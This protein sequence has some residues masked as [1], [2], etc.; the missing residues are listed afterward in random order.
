MDNKSNTA[1]H[2]TQSQYCF[3]WKYYI[4]VMWSLSRWVKVVT[5]DAS[6]RHVFLISTGRKLYYDVK[7]MQ[8]RMMQWRVFNRFSTVETR[9]SCLSE[10]SSVI[11]FK[12]YQTISTVYWV[13]TPSNLCEY[14]DSKD[15]GEYGEE[16]STDPSRSI[17]RGQCRPW[18]C[19]LCHVVW[20]ER[21][22]YLP[23][24][25]RRNHGKGESTNVLSR[26]LYAFHSFEP[27]LSHLDLKLKDVSVLGVQCK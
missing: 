7:C 21:Q 10:T 11:T 6:L 16:V 5:D 14:V 20:G 26:S 25:L 4:I 12:K 9:N 19:R 22:R 18:R 13:S 8:C 24:R 27:P 23:S 3:V 17:R 2:L 15:V 1:I